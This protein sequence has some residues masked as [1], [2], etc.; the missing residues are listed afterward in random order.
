MTEAFITKDRLT[1]KAYRFIEV[2]NE[3]ETSIRKYRPKEMGNTILKNE[4]G[5]AVDSRGEVSLDRKV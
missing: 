5:E 4:F 3:M 2:L 1:W